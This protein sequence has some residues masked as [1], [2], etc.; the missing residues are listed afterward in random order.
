MAPL[1]AEYAAKYAKF[2]SGQQIDVYENESAFRCVRGRCIWRG[3]LHAA[4]PQRHL[5]ALFTLAH[6]GGHAMH[7]VLS[8]EK[9]PFVTAAYTIFAWPRWPPPPMSASCWST[10]SRPPPTQG[11]FLLLQHAVDSIVGTFTQV[12]FADF[13][14]R[15][16]KL[17]E[18][19]KPITAAVLNDIYLDLLK[20]YYGDAVALDDAYKYTWTRIRTS[21]T[22]PTTCTSTPPALP[23]RPSC[24]AT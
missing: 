23:P 1:G 3:A 13:E 2:L 16:H 6:E 5:S 8:Y 17:V 22:R 11:R 18:Q 4:Q 9:Q 15:A 14:L 20:Q 10:C 19:G 24:L 21:T 12:L 7:T